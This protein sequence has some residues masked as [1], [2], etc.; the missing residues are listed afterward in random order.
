[1]PNELVDVLEL[2][3]CRLCSN[4]VKNDCNAAVPSVPVDDEVDEA[5]DAVLVPEVD[6]VPLVVP[7]RSAINLVKLLFSACKVDADRPDEEPE[8]AAVPSTS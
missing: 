8:D 4:E 3:P 5:P 7:P 2:L 1:M 6:E